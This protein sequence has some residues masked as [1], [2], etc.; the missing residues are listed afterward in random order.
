MV[1]DKG[2]G[3]IVPVRGGGGGAGGKGRGGGESMEFGG[4]LRLSSPK[5]VIFWYPFSDLLKRVKI[6]TILV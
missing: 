2:K 5:D 6:L 1:K 3:K 4:G